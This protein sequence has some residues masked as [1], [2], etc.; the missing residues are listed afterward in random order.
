MNLIINTWEYL[1]GNPN[2]LPDTTVTL[3]LFKS[4]LC[5]DMLCPPPKPRDMKLPDGTVIKEQLRFTIE[6]NVA[7]I[8]EL[9]TSLDKS[10]KSGIEIIMFTYQLWKD[11]HELL[12]TDWR[13][14]VIS[15]EE[16]DQLEL[17]REV[18]MFCNGWRDRYEQDYK[19]II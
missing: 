11:R 14:N 19:H 17:E 18:E 4:C 1:M 13:D 2:Y 6:D 12:K 15:R 16:S 9:A 3:D 8:C 7:Y 5:C 10:F